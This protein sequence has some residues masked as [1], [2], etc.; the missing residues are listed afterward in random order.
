MLRHQQGAGK[1]ECRSKAAHDYTH[2]LKFFIRQA[3]N[4]TLEPNHQDDEQSKQKASGGGSGQPLG[5]GAGSHTQ[6]ISECGLLSRVHSQSDA[7]ILRVRGGPENVNTGF[8]QG[9]VNVDWV[10]RDPS[11]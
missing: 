1:K 9:S 7:P 11:P 10:E 6:R 8:L 3:P 4:G 5:F 2:C